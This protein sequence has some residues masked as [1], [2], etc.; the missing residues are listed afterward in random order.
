M[1]KKNDVSA[2]ILA[3]GLSRRMNKNKSL[4]KLGEKT[5]IEIIYEKL[6]S[7]FE[8]IFISTNNADLYE[9]IPVPKILDHHKNLGPLGGFYASLLE[10]K[11]DRNFFISCDLPLV[12]PEIINEICDYPSKKDIVVP[13]IGDYKQYFCGVYRKDCWKTVDELLS[14]AR[15]RELGKNQNFSMKM[16]LSKSDFDLINIEES[17]HYKTGKFLN[18]NT[19]ADYKLVQQLHGNLIIA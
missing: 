15:R 5:I 8:N 4:L 16:L 2:F 10:T 11:T 18:M 7:V 19:I 17:E 9:S 1:F 13:I 6:E 12:T 3:G 14:K